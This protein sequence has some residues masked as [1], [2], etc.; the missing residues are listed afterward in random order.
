MSEVIDVHAHD[1]PAE[2]FELAPLTVTEVD[3]YGEFAIEP[4]RAERNAV[5]LRT[6]VRDRQPV[7]GAQRQERLLRGRGLRQ[8]L[9]PGLLEWAEVVSR[10]PWRRL[11]CGGGGRRGTEP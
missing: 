6:V 3:V 2:R 9:L 7:L 8:D 1:R 10:G 11:V 4:A 5:D